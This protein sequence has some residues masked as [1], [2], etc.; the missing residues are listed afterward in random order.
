MEWERQRARGKTGRYKI[1]YVPPTEAGFF[2]HNTK[3]QMATLP[4]F[5]QALQA[6]VGRLTRL[7]NFSYIPIERE[8]NGGLF[9]L[10]FALLLRT[11]KII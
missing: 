5:L 10:S 3:K 6:L 4:S 2:S 1:E 8:S 7:G 11:E 9:Y